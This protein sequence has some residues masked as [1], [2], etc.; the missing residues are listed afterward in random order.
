VIDSPTKEDPSRACSYIIFVI[1]DQEFKISNFNSYLI[2]SRYAEL[3]NKALIN[4][5]IGSRLERVGV[6]G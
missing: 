3:I 6:N 2:K 1:E 4:K 5:G